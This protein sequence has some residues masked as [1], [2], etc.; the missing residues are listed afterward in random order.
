MPKSSMTLGAYDR[1]VELV[2]TVAELSSL[3]MRRAIAQDFVLDHVDA[4]NLP[5]CA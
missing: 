2:A 4:S 5:R 3:A 1:A